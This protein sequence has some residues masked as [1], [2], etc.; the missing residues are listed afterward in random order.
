MT[1]VSE[2][3]RGDSAAVATGHSSARLSR[4]S[5]RIRGEVHA[6]THQADPRRCHRGSRLGGRVAVGGWLSLS[7]THSFC[8]SFVIG[9]LI[10][11]LS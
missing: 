6:R 5:R 4:S 7:N 10:L 9:H 1:W 2:T 8:S 3:V 11:N